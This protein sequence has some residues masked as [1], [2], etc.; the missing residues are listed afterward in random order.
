MYFSILNEINTQIWVLIEL[1]VTQIWVKSLN[2][3]CTWTQHLVS[4]L[5]LKWINYQNRSKSYSR[6]TIMNKKGVFRPIPIEW[7]HSVLFTLRIEDSLSSVEW[8][9]HS[10]GCGQ[11]LRKYWVKS[12]WNFTHFFYSVIYKILKWL[13]YW[14]ITILL[15]PLNVRSSILAYRLILGC[16]GSIRRDFSKFQFQEGET[17]PQILQYFLFKKRSSFR[18]NA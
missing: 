14:L 10:I 12:E 1:S 16:R 13:T 8:K 11:K 18:K 3:R 7:K 2:K 4:S 5:I 6:W 17:T 9:F 15:K